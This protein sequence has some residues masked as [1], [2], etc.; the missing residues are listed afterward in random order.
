E[1]EGYGGFP[2]VQMY[3]DTFVGLV[4]HFRA[5]LNDTCPVFH[6]QV[7]G[8]NTPLSPISYWMQ[9]REAHRT[10][11]IST[12]VGTAI[13]RTEEDLHFTFE[14]HHVVARMFADALLATQH[15]RQTKFYPP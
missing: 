11:P 15:G 3:Q 12:L 14:T 7:D 1:S 4:Q 9:I 8:L 13:G 10:L 6:L 2:S 5:D